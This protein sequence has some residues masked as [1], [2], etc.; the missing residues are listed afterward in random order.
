[1]R[2]LVAR[3]VLTWGLR[4]MGFGLC[5]GLVLYFIAGGSS[6]LLVIAPLYGAI[7][8]AAVGIAGGAYYG[9]AKSASRLKSLD[10]D[11]WSTPTLAG[12]TPR[13]VGADGAVTATDGIGVSTVAERRPPDGRTTPGPALH[14]LGWVLAFAIIG[15]LILGGLWFWQTR[16]RPRILV[17]SGIAMIRELSYD[18]AIAA[19]REA[20]R[21]R[22]DY[23]DAYTNLGIALVAQQ[24]SREA[25]AVLR[26]AIRLNPDDGSAHLALGKALNHLMAFGEP[27]ERKV[28]EAIGEYREAARLKPGSAEASYGLGRLLRRRGRFD[29]AVQAYQQATR[30]NYVPEFVYA[31]LEEAKGARDGAT[32]ISGRR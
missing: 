25:V 21:L 31:E 11:P 2:S 1:M 14:R 24:S 27:D 23:A 20:I 17:D 5:L 13:D 32:G 6:P 22:P 18:E 28:D 10:G 7:V 4:Y 8:G 26:E 3:T 12:E 30:A 15:A 9:W 19:C 29:E 16:V